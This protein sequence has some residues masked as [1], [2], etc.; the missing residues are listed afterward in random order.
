MPT[1]RI[2]RRPS[3]QPPVESVDRKEAKELEYVNPELAAASLM[4]Y[5]P[6]DAQMFINEASEQMQLPL[7]QMILGYVMRCAD[8]FEL[9]APHI[10]SQWESGGIANAPR[11]CGT[12]EQNFTSKFP[13]A[14]YCCDNCF[15]GKLATLGHSEMCPTKV[16]E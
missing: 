8:R 15:F 10:L 9:F 11:P 1:P 4:M 14:R 2:G 16:R 3:I 12:C 5:L 13:D 7:W 6:T